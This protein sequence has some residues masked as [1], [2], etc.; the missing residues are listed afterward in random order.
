[1]QA[2]MVIIIGTSMVVYPAAGLINYV[3][4][5]KLKFVIDPKSP[6]INHIPNVIF[7]KETAAKGTPLLTQQLIADEQSK[8]N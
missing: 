4:A 8:S 1:M 6:E 2:D 7:I 3:D 5:D